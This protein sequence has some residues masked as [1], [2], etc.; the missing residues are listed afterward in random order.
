MNAAPASKSI[1]REEY[2]Q[3]ILT[4]L[5][6]IE[7]NLDAD[8]SLETLA[9]LSY[10]SPYHFHRIFTSIVGETF[11]AHIRRARL[12]RAYNQLIHT[13]LTILDI[14]LAAHYSTHESFTRSFSQ[15]FGFTPSTLRNTIKANPFTRM[16]INFEGGR[17][18]LSYIHLFNK[19]I[20]VEVSIKNLDPIPVAYLRHIGD[21]MGVGETFSRLE[22]TLAQQKLKPN[23]SISLGIYHDDPDT[24]ETEKLRADICASV[25]SDFKPF[26]DIGF[27][28]VPAGKY[29]VAVHR[30][31]YHK[32]KETYNAFYGSWLPNS[33][34]TPRNQPPFE[35]YV[36]DP[37][38][39]APE[40]LITEI[41][42][43]IEG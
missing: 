27:Q 43:P 21:Y 37:A 34:H 16:N 33:G 42:M 31:P 8:L 3:R 7:N 39:T 35:I 25:S 18:S 30:G 36:T 20:H 15:H 24:T 10:F 12:Q 23:D 19:E 22:Q 17:P 32:L 13:D 40:D 11:K 29:A 6:Y 28:T 2:H 26:D 14:A 4:T 1:T 9:D 41:H 38:T 5:L